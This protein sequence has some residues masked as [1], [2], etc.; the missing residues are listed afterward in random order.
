MIELEDVR[1]YCLLLPEVS[2]GYPFGEDHLVFKVKDKMFCLMSLEAYP[3]TMNLKCE[4][5]RA[6]ELR[7][8]YDGIAPGY[9][10]NK[11]HWNTLTLDGSIPADVVLELVRHSYDRV[12]LGLK[13]GEREEIKEAL[14]IHDEAV[15]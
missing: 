3:S 6:I 12:V 4:P 15:A 14:S 7:E 9:H 11:K 10:M 2:E 5:D 13:K 8:Q 1:D